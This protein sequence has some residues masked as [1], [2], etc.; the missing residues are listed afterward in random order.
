MKGGSPEPTRSDSSFLMTRPINTLIRYAPH[1]GPAVRPIPVRGRFVVRRS[2][3]V[4]AGKGQRPSTHTTRRNKQCTARRQ[5][6]SRMQNG[7]EVHFCPSGQPPSGKARVRLSGSGPWESRSGI[8]QRSYF[9]YTPIR[10]EGAAAHERA[11]ERASEA[12]NRLAFSYMARETR[13]SRPMALPIN[14]DK[15]MAFFPRR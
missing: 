14:G 7:F 11:S 5:Q 6:Q 2:K 12:T 8:A 15:T 10:Y 9:V 4:K 13:R 3:G 1:D